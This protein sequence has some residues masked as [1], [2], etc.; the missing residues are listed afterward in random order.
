[1]APDSPI[2]QSAERRTVNPPGPWFEPGGRAKIQ[3]T[4]SFEWVFVWVFNQNAVL[5]QINSFLYCWLYQLKQALL[6]V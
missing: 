3:K 4:H 5:N 6:H 1:M 2:A